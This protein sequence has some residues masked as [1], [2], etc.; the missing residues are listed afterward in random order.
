MT[1]RLELP[2]HALSLRQP[3][4]SLLLHG[5]KKYE[6]RTWSPVAPR[7]FWIHAS[8]ALAPGWEFI[9]THPTL[10]SALKRCGLLEDC[11]DQTVWPRSAIIGI[12][13]IKRLYAPMEF[14]RGFS[15]RDAITVGGEP[16]SLDAYLWEIEKPRAYGPV[17]ADGKLNFWP[18][19]DKQRFALAH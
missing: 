9:I 11:F 1:N 8:A 13:N 16:M 2:T 10:R 12:A 15:L 3:Y 18:L 14:P 6:C 17:T 4:A 7:P 5:I 19:T